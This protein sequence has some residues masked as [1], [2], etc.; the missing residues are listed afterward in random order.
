MREAHSGKL[1]NEGCGT[2]R[3]CSGGGREAQP[4]FENKVMRADSALADQLSS[5]PLP[6]W[7]DAWYV[8]ARS[9]DVARRGVI[10]GRIA[11]RE[12]VLFRGENGVI[13]AIDAHCPHMG[14]HLKHGCVRGDRL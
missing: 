13:A 7:P 4:P 12:Y 10:S 2:R 5:A 6:R 14:A 1:S 8:V 9:S 3:T 11:H